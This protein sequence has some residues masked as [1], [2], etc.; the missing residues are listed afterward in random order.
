M[1]STIASLVDRVL[2]VLRKYGVTRAGVFGS[3]ARNDVS[4]SSDLDLLVELPP[5]SSLLE[6]VALEQD[7]SDE[8]GM[9]VDVHTY[10]SLH[11]RLRARILGEEVRIL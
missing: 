7:I 10:R 6:L 8:L 11:P 2:P 9:E 3:C 1:N 4:G 5:G